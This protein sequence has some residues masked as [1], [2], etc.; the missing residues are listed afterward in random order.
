MDYNV[1]LA[2][3]ALLFCFVAVV[4]VVPVFP[5]RS[6]CLVVKMLPPQAF[7]RFFCAILLLNVC[8]CSCSC[9][10]Q[11]RSVQAPGVITSPVQYAVAAPPVAI[12]ATRSFFHYSFR[13][14]K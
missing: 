11:S 4:I 3:P 7:V 2:L 13:L 14:K 6:L 8:A 9:A 12:D 1:A 10:T 5:F